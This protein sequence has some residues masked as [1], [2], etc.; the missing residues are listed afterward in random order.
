MK[1]DINKYNSKFN[2]KVEF[3][4]S[5]DFYIDH[6]FIE[7]ANNK[8]I[9]KL[10]VVDHHKQPG[11]LVHGGVYCSIAESACSF[12]ANANDT[13]NFVGISQNTDFIKSVERGYII[14]I[15]KPIKTGHTLQIWEA[16]MYI[17]DTD[18]LCATSR[19]KLFNTDK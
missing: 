6:V 5:F 1:F 14:C 10:K 19:V 9:T 7:V 17:D 12:G 11:G 16:N 4:K 3:N 18:I 8:V 15:A 13:G 2:Y